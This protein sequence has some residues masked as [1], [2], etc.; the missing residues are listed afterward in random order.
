MDSNEQPSWTGGDGPDKE[1]ME[2]IRARRLAKLG[3]SSTAPPK[4][5]E[6]KSPDAESPKP[7]AASPSSK[8]SEA[9]DPKQ[10]KIN[11]TPASS[12]S[13]TPNPFSQ[14]GVQSS[15][16]AGQPSPAKPSSAAANAP[17][18]PPSRK[19]N[20]A[21]TESDDDYANRVL[22]SIFRI[23]VNPHSMSIGGGQRLTFLPNLNEELNESGE[24]LKLSIASLDQ[25]ILEAAN[26]IPKDKPLLSYL[27]PCW[28]R[29]VKAA[30]NF[31]GTSGP[32]FEVHEESKRLCMSHCLFALTMPD[33]YGWA[34]YFRIEHD[35]PV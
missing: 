30:S 18:P 8:P 16:S 10:P 5:D 13:S 28:K 31:K 33:L 29:A 20:P 17:T 12:S 23:S 14:L 26:A 1:K 22:S 19:P 2:Q 9:E 11:I 24:P 32:R 15:G 35:H 25:A 27:L 4:P 3:T 7:A 34:L 21:A 6:S